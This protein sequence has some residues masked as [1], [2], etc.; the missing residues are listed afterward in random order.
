MILSRPKPA[1]ASRALSKAAC[2]AQGRFTGQSTE[3]AQGASA[4][5]LDA[6]GG[7]PDPSGRGLGS[8]TPHDPASRR[9]IEVLSQPPTEKRNS[10]KYIVILL[11]S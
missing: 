9:G 3:R 6:A 2:G 11:G 10:L 1:G 8:F 5:A 4:A 7:A